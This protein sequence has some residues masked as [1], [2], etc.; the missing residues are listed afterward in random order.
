MS[1]FASDAKSDGVEDNEINETFTNLNISEEITPEVGRIIIDYNDILSPFTEGN[2]GDIHVEIAPTNEEE[3]NID[4]VEVESNTCPELLRIMEKYGEPFLPDL[5]PLPA[6]ERNNILL[7]LY[8]I[9]NN[10]EMLRSEIIFPTVVSAKDNWKRI[11]NL[12]P[13]YNDC[14]I[15]I[16]REIIWRPEDDNGADDSGDDGNAPASPAS[17]ASSAEEDD[18]DDDDD[19]DDADDAGIRP[20]TL[21]IEHLSI[22]NMMKVLLV[23]GFH[24]RGMTNSKT[25]LEVRRKMLYDDIIR[26]YNKTTTPDSKRRKV[27]ELIKTFR[28]RKK[29]PQ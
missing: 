9:E 6:N 15:E 28:V 13:D 7:V 20:D 4:A 3:R 21:M 19:D 10:G 18:E 5:E 25:P 1:G 16:N 17:P 11:L 27:I 26:E 24:I 12:F 8:R 22:R 23:F 29:S 14:F 2:D